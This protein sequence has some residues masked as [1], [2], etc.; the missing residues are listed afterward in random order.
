M[1]KCFG[2][3]Q[4]GDVFSLLIK[5]EK[6][7][8]SEAIEWLAG[9]FNITLEYDQQTQQEAQEIKDHRTEM[10]AVASF[11]AE[12]YTTLLQQLPTDAPAILYL[13]S[14]GYSPQRIKPGTLAL[15]PTRGILLKPRLLTPANTRQPYNTGWW[16][17]KKVK[18][19]ISSATEI[20]VPIN[21]QNGLVVGFRARSI[22]SQFLPPSPLQGEGRG[23]LGPKYLNSTESL[24]YNKKKIW[25]GVW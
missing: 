8:V 13:Q 7:T 17:L 11:A 15:R 25:Y 12:K 21:D 20:I 4:S 6:L 14:R 23:E 22:P 19:G 16:L 18:T 3:G 5:M 9:H 1:Y 10:L 2:C 24:I